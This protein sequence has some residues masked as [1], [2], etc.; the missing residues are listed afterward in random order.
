MRWFRRRILTDMPLALEQAAKH[1]RT[2]E[3]RTRWIDEARELRT[4]IYHIEHADKPTRDAM[5]IA[6]GN[7]ELSLA[8]R[9]TQM[10]DVIREVHAMVQD[11]GAA[12][13]DLREMFSAIAETVD[14]RRT[15]VLAHDR[16]IASFRQSRDLSIAER[17]QHA[18][19]MVESREHRAQLQQGQANLVAAIEEI[20]KQLK[21]LADSINGRLTQLMDARATIERAAGRAAERQAGADRTDAE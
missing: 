1:A 13:V 5:Q 20:K 16:D 15:R 7:A 6:L 8:E 3:E 10:F 14:A 11:Q 4:I 21:E 12:A 2:E 18:A 19:E 9:I 17:S